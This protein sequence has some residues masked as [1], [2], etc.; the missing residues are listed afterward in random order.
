MAL[1]VN[2]GYDSGVSYL[3]AGR[4]R[5][6]QSAPRG[7]LASAAYARANRVAAAVRPDI[8]GTPHMDAA[9]LPAAFPVV[10]FALADGINSKS[11]TMNPQTAFR[12]QRLFATVLRNGASAALTAPLLTVLLVGQKPVIVTPDGVPLEALAQTAYDMNVLFPPSQPG[13]LY[14][15]TLRLPVALTTTDTITVIFGIHGSAVL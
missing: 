10:T 11:V 6:H 2:I 1:D 12:G 4:P 8:P 15:A 5:M 9:I 3:G 14:Q 7:P 13:V